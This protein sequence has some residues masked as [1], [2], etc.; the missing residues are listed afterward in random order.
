MGTLHHISYDRLGLKG[1]ILG[2]VTMSEDNI[3][4]VMLQ[5]LQRALQTLD[6]M[7]LAQT[8]GVGLLP[9]CAEEDL[10]GQDVL[11]TR[12]CYGRVNGC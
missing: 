3:D 1:D 2:V 7:L 5:A 10:G 6:D 12:P 4:V 9:R 11:V 8:A